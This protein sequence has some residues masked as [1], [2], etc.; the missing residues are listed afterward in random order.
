MIMFDHETLMRVGPGFVVLVLIIA[1]Y[2]IGVNV[3]AHLKE[4]R[5]RDDKGPE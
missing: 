1:A 3:Q 2:A 5:R 4:K